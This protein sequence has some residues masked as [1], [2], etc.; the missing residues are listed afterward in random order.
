[1]KLAAWMA[2]LGLSLVVRANGQCV[3]LEPLV[4]VHFDRGVRDSPPDRLPLLVTSKGDLLVSKGGAVTLLRTDSVCCQGRP[5][6]TF[7]S[8]MLTRSQL[9]RLL[10]AVNRVT[11]ASLE[12]CRVDADPD[13]PT[14]F[15]TEGS[16]EITLYRPGF[17]VSRF[18]L[19][20]STPSSGPVPGCDDAVAALEE[21]LIGLENALRRG[22][23]PLQCRP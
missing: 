11:A 12:N 3:D 2:I 23:R 19:Q 4:R 10:Q 8:G 1:M 5:G 13:P 21:E 22:V 7:V 16:S 18:L 20:H 17:T 15:T 9:T 6:R 14:G